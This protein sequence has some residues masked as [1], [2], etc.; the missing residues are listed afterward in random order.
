MLYI[1][2]WYYPWTPFDPNICWIRIID[3]W[4]LLKKRLQTRIAIQARFCPFAPVRIMLRVLCLTHK[5]GKPE[6]EFHAFNSDHFQNQFG[7]ISKTSWKP[8]QARIRGKWA[9]I[10]TRGASL[11]CWNCQST[12]AN[13]SG[14]TQSLF[15]FGF[16]NSV[17]SGCY[18]LELWISPKK[19]FARARIQPSGENLTVQKTT[20]NLFIKF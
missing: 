6:L 8:I 18:Q 12:F 17:I 13:A 5:F 2:I 20:Q 14:Q 16:H 9:R 3:Y 4:R 15:A 7:R 19:Q 1:V 11:R 10:H